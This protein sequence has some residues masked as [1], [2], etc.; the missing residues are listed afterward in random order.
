[1]PIRR[2]KKDR[3][4]DPEAATTSADDADL[5][6]HTNY[7]SFSDSAV[8]DPLAGAG[9][10][11]TTTTPPSC[12]PEEIKYR[13]FQSSISDLFLDETQERVDCCALACCGVLQ[14][15]RDRFLLSGVT[16]PTPAKRFV[17]HVLLPFCLFFFAGMAAL[18][19]R[20][21]V[22]NQVVATGLI[23]M[24]AFYFGLQCSKGRWKRMEIRKDLLYT[25][26]QVLRGNADDV[27]HLAR[28]RYNEEGEDNGDDN[29]NNNNHS[30]DYYQGQSRR[31]L[32][33]AHPCCLIGCYAED[34]P[35]P[36][37]QPYDVASPDDNL[38]RC[39]YETAFP[40]A[41]GAATC[42]GMHVQLC[43]VCA[44]A[45]EGRD[46]ETTVLPKNYTRIDYITMEHVS[47]Y[48][49]AIY[50]H[51][52][53]KDDNDNN[54]NDVDNIVDAAAE[55]GAN[56]PSPN[57]A[58]HHQQH[59]HHRWTVLGY[60]LSKL[61]YQLLQSL[62]W[63]WFCMLLW[64]FMGP[65]YWR[66]I[67][68]RRGNPHMF[69]LQNFVLLVLTFAQAFG[70]LWL[71]TYLLSRN[72]HSSN[73]QEQQQQQQEQSSS[74][75]SPRIE[76]SMDARIK[77][78][79]SGFFL[80]A[81]LALF[82]ECIVALVVDTFITLLLAAAGI[83]V[84]DNPETDGSSSSSQAAAN[85]LGSDFVPS[86][87]SSSH[88]S[89]LL[90]QL[91]VSLFSGNEENWDAN[92]TGRPD[93]AQTFGLDH[94]IF[95]T[96]YIFLATFFVAAFIEEL[97]KY[98]GYRMV[99]HPDF[100]S[101]SEIEEATSGLEHHRHI[102]EEDDD[103]DDDNGEH[104]HE[105]PVAIAAA[106]MDYSKQGESVQNRGAAITLAMVSTAIGFACCENL[107]YI[108]F[109]A[110]QSFD[111]QL[112]VLIERSFFPIHPILAAIQSIG[113]CRR[114]LEKAPSSKLGRIIFPAVCFHGTFDF[115]IIFISF[116]GKLVGQNYEEGDLRV[117]NTAEFLSV[118]ACVWVMCG[119]IFY[120]YN[121]CGKQRERLV[122]IDRQTSVDRSSLI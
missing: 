12:I 100:Y 74:S 94:P 55:E 21:K 44:I 26:Y 105:E 23:L 20:D 53:D 39:L 93:Y 96:I 37:E 36:L 50:R 85:W 114:E 45:Q 68:G 69:R 102:E 111:L 9:E 27:E 56:T 51:R 101:R 66:H 88:K 4:P 75:K 89:P 1:M 47:H 98:Y 22:A 29:D 3:Q 117:S 6:S 104:D 63:F 46:V 64:C 43:G 116:V 2:N 48:Y 110:G 49:P 119:A 95:Y 118:V 59:H 113:V 33:Q 30:R 86:A 62:L 40:C 120:L 106:H 83:D 19:I 90:V 42:C 79:A 61:S 11:A 38:A 32:G 80:S 82:W 10:G 13:G 91:F 25:K 76:L 34:R 52:Y 5:I 77:Y 35:L 57:Q 99:E 73:P 109:Y 78:F 87:V 41:S 8:D 18:H 107:M 65:I 14:N 81:S 28:Q 17:M 92:V 103:D 58:H 16:P 84:M 31:D 97:C 112:G 7:H 121:E 108:F 122:A 71:W 54:N 115:L 24:L 70:F 15:D 67:A 60:P 72:Q